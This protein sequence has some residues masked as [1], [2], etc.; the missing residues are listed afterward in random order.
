MHD[1]PPQIINLR[2]TL[3]RSVGF[4]TQD[5]DETISKAKYVL[6]TLLPELRIT[7]INLEPYINMEPEAALTWISGLSRTI[8]SELSRW[9]HREVS[10]HISKPKSYV[11]HT[12]GLRFTRNG[13]L[14][15]MMKAVRELTLLTHIHR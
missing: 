11:F 1:L 10:F 3:L 4:S 13:T 9:I 14:G 2:R 5:E 8:K 7:N 15:S 6:S 12:F